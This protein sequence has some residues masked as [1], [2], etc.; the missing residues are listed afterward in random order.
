M[1]IADYLGTRDNNFNLLRFIAASL[2]LVSHSY[3]LAVQGLAEP[4]RESL[5]T[6]WGSIAVDVFFVTSGFLVTRSLLQKRDLREF[7]LARALRIFP[8]LFVAMVITVGVVGIWFTSLDPTDYWLNKQTWKYLLK[9]SFLFRGIEWGLPGTLIGHHGQAEGAALNGSL[10]TLPVEVTMYVLLAVLFAAVSF[11][12]RYQDEVTRSHVMAIF[13]TA[14]ALASGL[15]NVVLNPY[16]DAGRELGLLAMFFAGGALYILRDAVRLHWGIFAASLA[17]V[18]VSTLAGARVFN[19]VY[20]MLVPYLVLFI[21]LVP[22][23]A[24]RQ[25][26]R[27]GD[28]SYGL[29]IYAFTVQQLLASRWIGI[30]PLQLMATSMAITLVFAVLSWHLIEERA[31]GLKGRLVRQ[32]FSPSKP[33]Q[34]VLQSTS[35]V[36]GV[37]FCVAMLVNSTWVLTTVRPFLARLF[38]S[39]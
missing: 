5:G 23:G 18:L 29:Y 38:Q 10:W 35:G 25:F 31:L 16:P 26:N 11:L 9:N 27:L 21:A 12:W 33:S 3:P 8:A 7:A 19:I 14:I 6:T 30:T 13:I 28:Y 32:R 24:I 20:F 34:S 17:A 15:A 39:V 1:K 36:V 2:V 37:V 4:L 22:A